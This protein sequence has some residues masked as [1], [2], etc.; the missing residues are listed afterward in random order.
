MSRLPNCSYPF[1]EH[2]HQQHAHA[3][4]TTRYCLYG[5]SVYF[6][7][8][9]KHEHIYRLRSQFTY[10][11]VIESI[12]GNYPTNR[13]QLV[14]F[15]ICHPCCVVCVCVCMLYT[16]CSNKRGQRRSN[17]IRNHIVGILFFIH[18][19]LHQFETMPV[20]CADMVTFV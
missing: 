19:T 3:H 12:A 4:I 9:P 14:C 18:H 8:F 5:R 20:H 2:T 7:S 13:S 10:P 16:Y 15:P 6:F 11:F 1:V 17:H